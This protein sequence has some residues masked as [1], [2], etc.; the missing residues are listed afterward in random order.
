M[1][2]AD[3]AEFRRIPDGDYRIVG[4]FQ[5]WITL[6]NVRNATD[7][8]V[9]SRDNLETGVQQYRVMAL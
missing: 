8:F 5:Q 9:A 3:Q 4:Y 7:R 2:I 6:E 1:S